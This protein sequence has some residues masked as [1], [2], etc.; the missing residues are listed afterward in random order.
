M[1]QEHIE[2]HL[3]SRLWYIEPVLAFLKQLA[4]QI[5]FCQQRIADIQLAIDEIC[6]NAIEHGSEG[7]DKGIAISIDVNDH[8][9]DILV[10][11]KGTRDRGSWLTAE[12]LEE[13]SQ[14]RAPDRER[15]HG[16]YMVEELSDE[17]KMEPNS[18]GG[19]DVRVRFSLSTDEQRRRDTNPSNK[20]DD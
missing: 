10:R 9:L 19:T 6:G 4:Q 17:V 15:G 16:I 12:K 14:R 8:Q 5:G 18:F 2:I 1:G 11:D 3:P 7:D 20:P 13:I